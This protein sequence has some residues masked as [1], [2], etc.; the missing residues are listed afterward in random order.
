[1]PYEKP[2]ECGDVLE[3]NEKTSIRLRANRVGEERL[4]FL[5]RHGR[6]DSPSA[7]T[8]DHRL[9]DLGRAPGG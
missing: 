4:G 1:M 3:G 7:T 9:G 2:E 8:G 5:D 6:V